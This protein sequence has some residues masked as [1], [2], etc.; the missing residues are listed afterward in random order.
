MAHR[1]DLTDGRHM[2]LTVLIIRV[3][4]VHHAFVLCLLLLLLLL[5]VLDVL[6]RI[7]QLLVLVIREMA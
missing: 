5:E 7:R 1:G 6:I 4:K 3:L 2:R